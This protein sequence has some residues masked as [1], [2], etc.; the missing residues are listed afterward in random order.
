MSLLIRR[1][2][3]VVSAEADGVCKSSVPR[4]S[5]FEMC[6][7]RLKPDSM[8]TPSRHTKSRVAVVVAVAHF[9]GAT[10]YIVDTVIDV[11]H[12]TILLIL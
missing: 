10:L 8:L 7:S 5:T 4:L 6:W 2:A 11:K 1:P 12:P 9:L 3:A